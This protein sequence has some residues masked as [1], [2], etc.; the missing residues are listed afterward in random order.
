[1][2]TISYFPS[3]NDDYC[4]PAVLQMVLAAF[5]I[6]K[7]QDELAIEAGTPRTPEAGTAPAAMVRVLKSYGLSVDA[8]ESQNLLEVSKA[9]Q[10]DAIPIVCFTEPT[11][12]WGHYA[13]VADV[14]ER[15]VF[16]CDPDTDRGACHAMAR[17][18]FE[19]RWHDHQFTKTN[20]W[21]AYAS[22]PEQ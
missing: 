9:L 20:K 7:T 6:S 2:R 8:G 16:L 18:E 12:E 13:I 14:T 3:E 19:R 4:G 5:G 21:A 10:R 22:K 1:M 15:E 17:E 11:W